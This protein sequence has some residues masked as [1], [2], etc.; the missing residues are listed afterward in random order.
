LVGARAALAAQRLLALDELLTAELRA[1]GRPLLE[2]HDPL[3][4]LVGELRDGLAVIAPHAGAVGALVGSLSE[5]QFDQALASPGE[6]AS[7]LPD[8]LASLRSTLGDVSPHAAAIAACEYV[9]DRAA[10]ES[11]RLSE[12]LDRIERG[13]AA[14]GNFT[15]PF[16]CALMLLL[17]GAG[18]VATI[19]LGGASALALSIASQIALGA[20]GCSGAGC[21]DVLRQLR[22]D[23]TAHSPTSTDARAPAATPIRLPLAPPRIVRGPGWVEINGIRVPLR[24]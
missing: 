3:R 11:E 13:D 21:A 16:A 5:E 15:G 12:Q 17:V 9:H 18:V 8:A 14:P 4:S 6:A 19:G 24:L 7:A 2:E 1:P 10:D 23:P 20:S 22:A